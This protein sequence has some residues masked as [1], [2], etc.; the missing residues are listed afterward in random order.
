M[1]FFVATTLSLVVLLG[2]ANSGTFFLHLL[3]LSLQKMHSNRL[4]S[5]AAATAS[6]GSFFLMN[7]EPTLVLFSPSLF[8]PVFFT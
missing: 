3:F 5:V 6:V 1:K 7:Q 4:I 2:E 8:I